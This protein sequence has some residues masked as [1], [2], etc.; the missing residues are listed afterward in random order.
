VWPKTEGAA[1]VLKPK[2]DGGFDVVGTFSA[3]ELL[4]AGG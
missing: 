4:K 2:G 3:A 1:F